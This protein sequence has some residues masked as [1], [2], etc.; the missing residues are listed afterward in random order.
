MQNIYVETYGCSNNIAES[1][2]I[3]G[4][5]SNK[6]FI[7]VNNIEN[8]D[9]I[10]INTCSVKEATVNKMLYRIKQILTK[11]PDKKLVIAGCLP[12]THYSEIKEIAPNASIVS[13]NHITKI[14]KAIFKIIKNEK[15]EF[16]GKNKEVK[17]LLPKIQENKIVSIIPICSGCNSFCYFCATKYAKGDIFSFP[18]DKIIKEIEIAKEYGAKEFWIT[19]QDVSCYG[20]DRSEVSLL[21]NLLE[22]IL[23]TIKGKYFI[24]IGMMNPKN[25]IKISNEMLRIYKDER[26]FKFLHLPVQSGSNKVLKLMNRGYEKEDFIDIVEKFRR[27][28]KELNLWTDIIVGYPGETEEDFLETVELIK[29]VEPNKVNISKFSPHKIVP[30]SKMKQIPTNIKNERSKILYEICK[31]IT[32][33]RNK[34]WIGWEGEVLI[35]KIIKGKGYVGRNY[36]YEPI[37]IQNDKKILRNLLGCYINV[38]IV[39]TRGN[40]LVGKILE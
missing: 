7:L 3:K 8:S 21:P 9:I 40:L 14:D 23:S 16:V 31:E 33:K 38:R 6:G 25:L 10:I 2:I 5:L 29:K 24:R 39:E 15:V 26:I 20:L 11:Y 37:I 28:F 34:I 22:N 4:I 17:V 18:E 13:T 19:G 1:Q 35:D 30:S 36:A 12:E 32:N 27:H